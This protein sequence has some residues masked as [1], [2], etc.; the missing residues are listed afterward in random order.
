MFQHRELGLIQ[1]YQVGVTL[2]MTVLFWGY[3]LILDN[4][5]PGFSLMGFSTYL[6][7]FLAIT[8]GF[9]VSFLSSKQNDI[10]SMTSGIMESHRFIWPHMVFATAITFMFAFI[11][12]DHEIS[13]LFLFTYIPLTYVVLVVINR[14]F[15]LGIL[16]R[17]LPHQKQKLLLIG[18]PDELPKLESLLSK[19][20][21]FGLETVGMLTEADE[22]ALPEGIRKLGGP[23]DLEQVLDSH[24][25]ENIFIVGS[26]KD[27][28]WLS[29]WMKQ[30]EARGCRVSLVNDLDVFLQRRLSYF[31]CDDI[32]LIE[33]R[34]EPLQNVVNRAVKR[35]FDICVSFLV[36]L[37]ILPPLILLV[38]ILQRIQ[39]PGPLF[40]KQRRS[41]LHN[42][43]FIIFK[44][45]TM[46]A[47]RCNSP[48]QA[49]RHD[50]R[51]FPAGRW[52]RKFSLDEFPQFFNVLSGQM[53]IIGPRPHMPEHDEIFEETMS[54]YRIRHFVTPGLSGLAQ[55]RGYRGETMTKELIV[56]RVECDIEYIETWSL[57]LDVRV[58]WRTL[59]EILKPSKSAY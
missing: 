5:I 27:R 20:K 6:E 24:R 26:P 52:L 2:V 16:Q 55:I 9:Q 51:I 46:Y 32:D 49:T 58:L 13:R 18:M 14:Y 45:R 34:E 37:L 25:I 21:L 31:R 3:F 15:A 11:K 50:D 47:D 35:I 33:L 23:H 48:R 42:N 12:R 1:S 10:F 43:P 44:F 53:S 41:G 8:L 30:A 28:R 38:W 59:L 7:Y 22:G 17:F 39:A 40:F 29:G 19:A 56:K 36:V 4:L 54:A 57:P